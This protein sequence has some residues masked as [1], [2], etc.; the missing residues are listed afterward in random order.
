MVPREQI[1]PHLWAGFLLAAL[2]I[3]GMTLTEVSQVL[4][5]SLRSRVEPEPEIMEF[6][7]VEPEPLPSTV[8][9]FDARLPESELDSTPDRE[10]KQPNQP[11]RADPK[12][13]APVEASPPLDGLPGELPSDDSPDLHVASDGQ[14]SESGQPLPASLGGSSG[15]LRAAF[16]T[17]GTHDDL[18]DVDEGVTNVL[19][20]KRNLY[21]SFFNRM[22]ARVSEHWEPEAVNKAA[23]PNQKIYGTSARTTVLWVQLDE[24]GTVTKIVV[25]RSSD[26][27]HLDEEAIRALKAAAPFPNPPEGLIDGEGHIEFDFGFTLDFVDGGRIFRYQR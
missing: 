26:A 3:N 10:A 23:D 11:K 7:M 22:S 8:E 24:Q 16:G 14:Q 13:P 18:R 5:D 6:E 21:A 27:E 25:K 2:L 4:A 15:A 20:S 12:P 19:A 9:P 17:H 1:P